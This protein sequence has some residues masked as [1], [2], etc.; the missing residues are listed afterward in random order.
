MSEIN[1]IKYKYI[2]CWSNHWKGVVFY[3]HKSKEENFLSD[4]NIVLAELNEK[5]IDIE[6][7]KKEYYYLVGILQFYLFLVR[8]NF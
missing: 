4:L 5:I 8:L 3:I 1:H 2:N 7:Y 6:T